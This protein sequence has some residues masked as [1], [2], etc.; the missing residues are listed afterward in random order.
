[1]VSKV[2]HLNLISRFL[3]EELNSRSEYSQKIASTF[4]GINQ[5]F[6]DRLNEA[7]TFFTFYNTKY[8]VMWRV[9]A[10]SNVI[11]NGGNNL[12]RAFEDLVFQ[13]CF[14]VLRLVLRKN[15][16]IDTGLVL[17]RAVERY[18]IEVVVLLVKLKAN[19]NVKN[20]YNHS[21]LNM[22]VRKDHPEVLSLLLENGADVELPNEAG[23]TALVYAVKKGKVNVLRV[24]LNHGAMVNFYSSSLC[25]N[26]SSNSSSPDSRNLDARTPL[27]YAKDV[28]NIQVVNL[29]IEHG[30]D[31]I[32]AE[33]DLP[34]DT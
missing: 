9:I 28:G 3:I 10:Y 4:I 13:K 5:S 33:T 8:E 2:S 6:T 17:I 18:N 23:H 27:M 29:L 31:E 12:T 7:A 24:L 34:I 14:K 26:T 22:A 19:L 16:F 21:A 20:R 25:K 15:I 1:M 11:E 32:S 30:A